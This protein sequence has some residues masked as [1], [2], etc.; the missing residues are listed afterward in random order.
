VWHLDE[1]VYFRPESG[2]LLLSPCDETPSQPGVPAVDPLAAESLAVKL[3]RAFPRLAAVTVALAWAGLRTFAADR[4]P[5]IGPD[6]RVE[7][8]FWIAGLGGHGVTTSLSAG[9]LAAKL[10]LE[11]R[12]DAGNP[13]SPARFA[14][15]G[16]P[17]TSRARQAG[18]SAPAAAS[19]APARA[20]GVSR[21]RGGRSY[22][23]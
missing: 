14:A 22:E 2:G 10:L 13:F 21:I 9:E 5:V 4:L 20:E 7:G 1:G 3:P 19:S 15:P 6:P 8:F 23:S 16:A 18:P 11:P 17:D 12:R